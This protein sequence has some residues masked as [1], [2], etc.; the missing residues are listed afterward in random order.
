VT[1]VRREVKI[2]TNEDDWRELEATFDSL[3]YVYAGHSIPEF[4]WID[5]LQAA[6]VAVNVVF[7]SFGEEL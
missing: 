4:V 3:S 1:D 5:L 7:D 2:R 6:G